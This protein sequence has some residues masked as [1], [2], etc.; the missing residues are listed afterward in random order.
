MARRRTCFI[1]FLTMLTGWV[2][3]VQAVRH[4]FPPDILHVDYD[5]DDPSV[6]RPMVINRGG[7]AD[8]AGRVKRSPADGVGTG[9]GSSPAAAASLSVAGMKDSK[10]STPQVIETKVSIVRWEVTVK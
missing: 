10:S 9:P 3:S 4:G 7:S 2:S 1:I 5:E 6:R 8:G